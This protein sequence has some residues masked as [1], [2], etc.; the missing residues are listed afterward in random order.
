MLTLVVLG[1][2]HQFLS[3]TNHVVQDASEAAMPL[4]VLVVTDLTLIAYE[5]V[6]RWN[7]THWLFRMKTIKMDLFVAWNTKL[8]KQPEKS[9]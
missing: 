4:I 3:R 1:L 7:M 6:R 9:P 5:L 2:G 8:D